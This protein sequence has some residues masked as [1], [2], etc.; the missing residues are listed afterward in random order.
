MGNEECYLLHLWLKLKCAMSYIHKL[1]Q[2][3]KTGEY[4]Q[5]RIRDVIISA[6]GSI[7][8]EHLAGIIYLQCCLYSCCHEW[9][10]SN[11]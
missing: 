11:M 4:M 1:E 5:N 9:E 6:N 3:P 8:L 7:H 2:T 10:I